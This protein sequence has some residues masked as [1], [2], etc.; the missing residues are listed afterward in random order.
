VRVLESGV[1][2][3]DFRFRISGFGFRASDFRGSRSWFWVSG[4]RFQVPGFGFRVSGVEP[5]RGSSE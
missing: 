3:N 1:W 4:F 5:A 2:W